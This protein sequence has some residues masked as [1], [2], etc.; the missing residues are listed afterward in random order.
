MS[1]SI[2]APIKKPQ[3]VTPEAFSSPETKKTSTALQR[4]EV[5]NPG[6][7]PGWLRGEPHH[8]YVDYKT[9]PAMSIIKYRGRRMSIRNDSPERALVAKIPAAALPYVKLLYKLKESPCLKI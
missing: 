7:L 3:A 2:R 5:I 4:V 6:Y 1:S 9:E 8:L